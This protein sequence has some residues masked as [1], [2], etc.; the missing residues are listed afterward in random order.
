[1]RDLGIYINYNAY[2]ATVEDLYYRPDQL[3]QLI[4]PYQSPFDFIA[5]S[6]TFARLRDGYE[7]DMAK[8][9][10]LKPEL[11]AETY[12]LY[13]LPAQTWARRV[14][15]VLGNQLAQE[16]TNRAHALL[17]SLPEGGYVVSVRA[18][19]AN[20]RGAD[21]LCRAFPTGGGRQ[22]A[23]GIN[24]LDEDLYEQFVAKFKKIYA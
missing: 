1:M 19:L 9:Q 20:K 5:G 16:S 18:P 7:E 10:A 22:A 17:T 15:G 12:A 21:E 4:Q 23:A 14:S 8:T 13:I 2:G 24:R 11:E 3:F 6:E